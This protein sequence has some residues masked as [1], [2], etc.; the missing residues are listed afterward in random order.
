M[1]RREIVV[2]RAHRLPKPL[3]LPEKVPRDVIAR[4]HFYHVKEALMQRARKEPKLPDPYSEITPIQAYNASSQQ[5]GP[6]Y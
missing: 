2:D 6:P 5:I 3:F 1:S 4:V